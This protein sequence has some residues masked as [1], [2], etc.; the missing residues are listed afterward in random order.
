MYCSFEEGEITNVAVAPEEQ[1]GGIGRRMME[2]HIKQAKAKGIQRAILE[3][4]ISNGNA[5]RLY[6]ALGFCNSG[7]RKGFYELPREDGVV[8]SLDI[9]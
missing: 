9:V 2:F 4:R 6:E 7:I 3:V 1:G 5:I 8:M